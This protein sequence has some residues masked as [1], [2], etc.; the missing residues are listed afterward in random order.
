[1][2]PH[3][4]QYHH[5]HPQPHPG[6]S[7]LPPTSAHPPLGTR[8]HDNTIQLVDILGSGGY[9]VVFRGVDLSSKRG[10]KYAV[11]CMSKAKGRRTSHVRE[12]N[13]H[14][15]VSGHPGVVEMYG[16][17]EDDKFTYF[18]MEYA[19]SH[20]LFHQI[21]HESRYLARDE[22]IRDVF[23]QLVDGVQHCHDSG[24]FH[25]DLKPENVMCFE[26]GARVAI[27]D[28]GLATSDTASCEFRTG[29]VYHMSPG[30]FQR[31]RPH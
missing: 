20:D 7:K 15:Q 17:V 30:V 31:A 6:M 14:L 29:S 2:S 9:G 16:A 11:K 24:V 1:M 27:T 13:F 26:G 21:L 18:I 28:F 4:L 25:R 3:P 5:H 8:I 19:T 23:L 12:L 22:T 10:R